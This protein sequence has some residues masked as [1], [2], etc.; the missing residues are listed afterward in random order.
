MDARGRA[1]DVEGTHG[2]LGAGL[3]DGLRRDDADGFAHLNH[4]AGAEVTA[5][6]EDADAALG[7]AGEHGADFDLFDAGGLDGRGEVFV[8]LLVDFDDGLAFEVFETLERDAAD[9][10]VAQRLDGFAGFDDGRDVDAFDGAAVVVRDDDILRDVDE[11]AGE[12]ARVRGLQR[13]IRETLAGAVGGDEVLEHGEA[14]AEVGR[15]GRLDD[16][17]GGLGHE[18]AHAGELTDLLFGSAGAGV[19]HDVDRVHGAV[20]VGLLHVVEHLV[21]DALGDGRPELDDLVVALTVG[22]GAVEILLLNVDDLLLGVAR[23]RCTST[24]E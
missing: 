6:A 13:R 17:A 1:A 3:A 8:D 22:D 18:T 24:P 14:F 21:G 7:L 20:F 5:I 12:V 11:P 9:D 16:F 19:G 23:R 4:L 2:E 10:A 15:D